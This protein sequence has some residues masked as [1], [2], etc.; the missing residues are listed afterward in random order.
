MNAWTKGWGDLSGS[1]L[2]RGLGCTASEGKRKQGHRGSQ[3][4]ET[5][6]SFLSSPSP[7]DGPESHSL[8]DRPGHSERLMPSITTTQPQAPP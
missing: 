3:L 8:G 1:D 4:Q 5:V 2:D 6:G 7:A